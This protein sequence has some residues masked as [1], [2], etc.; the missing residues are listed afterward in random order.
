MKYS[1]FYLVFNLNDAWYFDVRS[2]CADGN[3][4]AR[5][6]GET[7]G[8]MRYNK[9]T[10]ILYKIANRLLSSVDRLAEFYSSNYIVKGKGK[11]WNKYISLK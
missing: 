10:Q 8:W 3:L 11:V 2:R 4:R 5:N 6:F 1:V 7:G 9:Q